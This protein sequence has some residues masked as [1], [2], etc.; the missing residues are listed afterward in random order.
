[1]SFCPN[2]GTALNEN[3]AVCPSCGFP[4][5]STGQKGTTQPNTNPMQ[6]GPTP[7]Q[8]SPTPRQGGF[9]GGPGFNQPYMTDPTDHTPEMD[10]KDISENKVVAMLPYLM[11][12]I[13]IIICALLSKESKY[14]AF[15]V[16]QALKLEVCSSLLVIV[17]VLLIWTLIVPLA[18]LICSVILF[19]VRIIGFFGVA[20]GKAKELPIVK[21]LGFLK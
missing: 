5:N 2:C 3:A 17:S 8:S 20:N 18:G 10:P 15:H 7:M 4:L 14:A 1:M 13:G 6:G 12:F 11:G 21:G 9:Q 19:V 16:R